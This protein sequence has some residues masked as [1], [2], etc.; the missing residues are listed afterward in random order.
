MRVLAAPPPLPLPPPTTVR[1]PSINPA[2]VLEPRPSEHSGAA[3][4]ASPCNRSAVRVP[5]FFCVSCRVSVCVLCVLCV[6]YGC[7]C[8]RLCV[9]VPSIFDVRGGVLGRVLKV[10]VWLAV[11]MTV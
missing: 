11:G 7:L 9:C 3:P 6:Q 1:Q 8:D 10:V 4:P 5:L 2:P